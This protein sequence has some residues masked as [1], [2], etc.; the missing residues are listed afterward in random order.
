LQKV[1]SLK[2]RMKSSPTL[3]GLKTRGLMMGTYRALK[4][5]LAVKMSLD[6]RK[7]QW[8]S[9]NLNRVKDE[10]NSKDLPSGFISSEGYDIQPGGG[11]RIHPQT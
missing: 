6:L 2:T 9:I 11:S 1:K 4:G 3:G 8:R 7:V 5:V 10:K